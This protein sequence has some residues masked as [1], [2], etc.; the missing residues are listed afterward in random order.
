M[1]GGDH[2]DTV[3]S[4]HNLMRFYQDSPSGL[5]TRECWQHM[6]SHMYISL[7]LQSSYIFKNVYVCICVR[8]CSPP[9]A[10]TRPSF[11]RPNRPAAR[12]ARNDVGTKALTRC[13]RRSRDASP[14]MLHATHGSFAQSYVNGF[15]RS[16]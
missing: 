15:G 3:A 12:P 6:L 9:Y 2:R 5:H 4:V 14:V 7:H 10:P 16:S 11:N 1:L 8:I 13:I